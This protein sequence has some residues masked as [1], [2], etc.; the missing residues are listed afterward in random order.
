MDTKTHKSTVLQNGKRHRK[1]SLASL[2]DG[3]T[4]VLIESVARY[5]GQIA[6]SEAKVLRLE[7][8]YLRGND[9]VKR[10]P[11]GK[12]EIVG[13]VKPVESKVKFV[14]GTI[15]HAKKDR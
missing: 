15:L 9:I 6:I 8:T 5:A 10:H 12:I 3:E 2:E 7:V 11:D 4:L 14:K 1:I 13:K